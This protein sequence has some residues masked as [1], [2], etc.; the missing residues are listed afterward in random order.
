MRN[1]LSI[2]WI[3][4]LG[5][6]GASA[7]TFRYRAS[8]EPV[9]REG[10]YRILLSP[11]VIGH[12]NA[13]Q[14]DLRLHDGQGRE[15]P[16]FIRRE[17]AVQQKSL[18]KEYELLPDPNPE[19][20]RT[21]LILRNPDRTKIDNIRL[22]IKNANVRKKA[23]LSGSNDARSWYIIEDQLLLSS[24][25]SREA[26]AEL[27][28]L[29]FPLSDY[30]YYRLQ[31]NDSA[32]APLNIVRAGYYDTSTESGKYTEVPGLALRKKDSTEV[33]RTYLFFSSPQL[34]LVDKLE[35]DIAGPAHFLRS[36]T[37]L[38]KL[39]QKDRRGKEETY[40]APVQDFQLSSEQENTLLLPGLRSGNFVLVIENRDNPPLQIEAV[41]PFQLH[42]YLVAELQPEKPYHLVF[43]HPEV[44]PPAYDLAH[45]QD[46]V[47]SSTPMLQPGPVHRNPALS[48][49]AAS[50][51]NLL[52]HLFSNELVI[53][54]ALLLVIGFLAVMSFQMLREKQKQ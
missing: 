39:R 30:E 38:E 28:I 14:S 26:T 34:P 45:F 49:P 22:L 37:L 2:L 23:Q 36:A 12:L 44:R 50:Q 19:K 42:T 21:T 7:Q 15:A 41:R 18:F 53:W 48:T 31:I 47:T 54:A 3:V 24:L 52:V 29:N 6:S 32:S 16:Y 5:W 17:E 51:P 4:L 25:N 11:E 10:F 40:W 46:Q 43:G 13:R 33:K 8:V 35:L 27:K 9:E 20:G 1:T